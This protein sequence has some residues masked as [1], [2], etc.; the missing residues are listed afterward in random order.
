MRLQQIKQINLPKTGDILR[1]KHILLQL[2]VSEGNSLSTRTILEGNSK[3]SF[4]YRNNKMKAS[5]KLC[6]HY[7]IDFS[8]TIR[9][10]RLLLF[11][12]F[13]NFSIAVLYIG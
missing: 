9:G 2:F 6:Y 13:I 3:D 8:D 12:H 10:F 1:P 5:M 11:F 4:L 7:A